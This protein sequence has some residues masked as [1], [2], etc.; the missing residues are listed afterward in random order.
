MKVISFLNYPVC[1]RYSFYNSWRTLNTTRL[2]EHW[3]RSL[4]T[5][6]ILEFI[7]EQ[8]WKR[9]YFFLL[10]FKTNFHRGL[11]TNPVG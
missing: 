8:Y 9:A 7:R 1:Q 3:N 2:L 4:L 5:S 10:T 11:R 6:V